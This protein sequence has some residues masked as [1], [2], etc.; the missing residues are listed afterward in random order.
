MSD[1]YDV[2]RQVRASKASPDANAADHSQDAVVK[3]YCSRLRS[4]NLVDCRDVVKVIGEALEDYE[5]KLEV[6]SFIRDFLA[7]C[8]IMV[9]ASDP[10]V[11]SEVDLLR[12]MLRGS[13]VKATLLRPE[14]SL[15]SSLVGGGHKFSLVS[16]A[17]DDAGIIEA[18]DYE[19]AT[20]ASSST[21]EY[22]TRWAEGYLRLMVNSRDELANARILCG[23][24]GVL[25]EAAFNIMR[26]E[27]GKTKMPIYQ[28]W[29]FFT[30]Y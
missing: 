28:V 30:F 13:S 17:V 1:V 20:S 21:E 14:S 29:E 16:E 26:R 27:A 15:D 2:L 3:S 11:S 7:S 25:D 22:C 5:R 8:A 9:G 23:P 4:S 24:F 10:K 19:D 6:S 18:A 12:L